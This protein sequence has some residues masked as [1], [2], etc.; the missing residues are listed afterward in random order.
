MRRG[1]LLLWC[2]RERESFNQQLEALKAG[3]LQILEM[4]KAGLR[5]IS[6]RAIARLTANIAELDKVLAS[7]RPPDDLVGASALLKLSPRLPGADE[8]IELR[9]P[10]GKCSATEP[11]FAAAPPSRNVKPPRHSMNTLSAVGLYIVCHR[12]LS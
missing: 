6:G 4:D 12:V 5:D 10:L 3:R 1:A 9:R 11:F 8:V 2:A 7:L